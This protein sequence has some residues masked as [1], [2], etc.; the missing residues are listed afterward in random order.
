MNL[1]K[2]KTLYV[3]QLSTEAQVLTKELLEMAGI[4]EEDIELAMDSRLADLSDTIN[5][6]DVISAELSVAFTKVEQEFN[7]ASDMDT[8]LE[9]YRIKRAIELKIEAIAEGVTPAFWAVETLAGVTR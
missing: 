1:N 8:R 5:I 7:E 6:N 3:A 9:K 2:I 4:S